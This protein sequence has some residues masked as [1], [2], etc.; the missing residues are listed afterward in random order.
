[1]KIIARTFA[2]LAFAAVIVG[3]LL[4]LGATTSLASG[5]ERPDFAAAQAQASGTT[6]AT[7]SSTT[8]ATSS[9]DTTSAA[10]P[11]RGE[12]GEGA[13]LFG[14]VEILKNLAIVGVITAIVAGGKRLLGRRGPPAPRPQAAA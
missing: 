10:M 14:A 11:P 12:G 4:T 2:I 1:M 6:G 5:G 9:T 7:A 13:S 8:S 3:G